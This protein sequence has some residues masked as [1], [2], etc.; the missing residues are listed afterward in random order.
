MDE[1]SEVA[2]VTRAVFLALTRVRDAMIME[3][4][5]TARLATQ[6]GDAHN[7]AHHHRDE[8]PSAHV[9]E[10]GAPVETG[11]LTS[12]H[13]LLH[14]S[15]K[16]VDKFAKE[17]THDLEMNLGKVTPVRMPPRRRTR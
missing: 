5:M 13:G 15:P 1:V 3:F 11:K 12:S 4:D 10:D 6:G 9:H 14:L 16:Q 7:A 17:M 2:E 8:N